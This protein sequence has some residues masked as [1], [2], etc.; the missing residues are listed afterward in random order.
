MDI[1]RNPLFQ[2]ITFGYKSAEAERRADWNLLDSGFFER[3]G[4]VQDLLAS[5]RFI[6]LGYKGSGKSAIA[7]HLDIV[8]ESDPET[9]VDIA[10]LK[11]FP[12]DDVPKIVPGDDNLVV[13]TTLAWSILLLLRTIDSISKDQLARDPEDNL[14][15]VLKHLQHLGLLKRKKFRDLVFR[16]REVNLSLE[17]PKIIK[18]DIA[19]DGQSGLATLKVARDVLLETVLSVE[20]DSRHIIVIDGLDEVFDGFERYYATIAA[21]MHEADSLNAAFAEVDGCSKILILCRTDIFERLPSANINK[22]RDY[23]FVID[24][25]QTP[26]Q[27][28]SSKLT[29]LATHRARMSGYSGANV[30]ADYLPMW[31]DRRYAGPIETS[32][33]L[34]D[35]TRHT[36]RDFLQVL[37]HIQRSLAKATSRIRVDDVFEGLRTYSSEYFLPE[38][39]D[40]LAGYLDPDQISDYLR[41]V[42]G[43]RRREFT[44]DDLRSYAERAGMGDIGDLEEVV[45]ILFDCSAIGNIVTRPRGD[46]R[47]PGTYYTFR[48]RNRNSSVNYDERFVI[49]RGLWKSFNL[50]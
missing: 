19:F 30:V 8:T 46:G 23:A 31:L 28:G 20:T 27:P 49:H 15:T 40:E 4:T 45:R 24:W 10:L 25:Y 2:Q 5:P 17:L 36:P 48:Y 42:G 12:F 39:K 47:P 41:I 43:V 11:D 13:R 22:L 34:L 14:P 1:A 33:F 9:F 16:T 32:R 35:H 21:L 7:E 38:V 50:T 18:G 6:V 26:R 37:H 3:D 29:D 44:L